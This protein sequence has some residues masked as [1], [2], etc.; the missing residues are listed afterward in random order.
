MQ[1]IQLKNYLQSVPDET[2]ILVYVQKTN[3]VRHLIMSDLDQNHDGAIIID[4]EYRADDK[5]TVNIYI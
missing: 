3:E 5:H 2:N 1:A 4:A